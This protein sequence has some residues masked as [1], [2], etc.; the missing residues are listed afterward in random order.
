VPDGQYRLAVD[1]PGFGES[2]AEA[3]ALT[4]AE[5]A[6]AAAPLLAPGTVVVGY[7]YGGPVALR[8]AADHPDT[9]AGVVLVGSAA[10]PAL[11]V[12]HPLQTLAALD[13]FSQLLPA[14]LAISN[15]E[16]MAL[17]PELQVLAGDLGRIEAP[18][19]II[20]GLRD[21]LVPPENASF[22]AAHLAQD[23]PVRVLLI[24]EG[25]HFLPWTHPELI[26][27]AIGCAVAGADGQPAPSDDPALSSR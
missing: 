21:T 20:Q 25:D 14:E 8:L 12:I 17:E 26:E 2:S 22:V 18:V 9:V 19:T 10:D 15:A 23:L 11:E 13:F 27:Q 16:L 7:S 6:A 5:Q 4:L 3:P 24:E 1:R